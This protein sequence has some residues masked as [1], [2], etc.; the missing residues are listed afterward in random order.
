MDDVTL[1][2]EQEL[3]NIVIQGAAQEQEIRVPVE[4]TYQTGAGVVDR[5]QTLSQMQTNVLA[6][7]SKR[8]PDYTKYV[9]NMVDAGFLPESAMDQPTSAANNLQYPVQV[10]DAYR[11]DGG[12]M[13]FN[14]WFDW[15]ASTARA[16]RGAQ[17]QGFGG[18]GAY[19]GPVKSIT[20]MAES[21]IRKS[22]TTIAIE[23]LGRPVEDNE[24]DRIIKKMRKAEQ[25]Q[26]DITTRSTG[27]TVTEQGLTAQGRDDILRDLIS[28]NPEYE[29]FQVD[30]TVLDSMLDFVNKKKQVSGA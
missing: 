27:K 18:G 8:S 11:K 26:P 30:T 12:E 15:Y 10:F 5:Y 23:L 9:E 21:D 1:A 3:N 20:E 17:T 2:T 22:A 7:A 25:Q 13:V 28:D 19:T 4:S 16:Q 14:E 6:W 29:Q 24:M